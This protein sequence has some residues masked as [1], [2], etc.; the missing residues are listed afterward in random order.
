MKKLALFVAVAN[1]CILSSNA[2]AGYGHAGKAYTKLDLGWGVQQ[3]KQTLSGTLATSGEDL[4]D[5]IAIGAGLGYY[6][7]DS[8]RFDGMLYYDRGMKSKV[9]AV[10][11]ATNVTIRGKEQSLGFFVN[12]TYDFLN[13]S[14]ITPY[15]TGGAGFLRNEF[16]TE[17]VTSTLNKAGKS[18]FN[19]AY[20][21][22]VGISYHISS[23]LDI[24][25]GYRYIKKGSDKYNLTLSA[26]STTVKAETEPEH[27][28]IIGFRS[29]F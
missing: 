14:N 11:G 26:I 8:L 23:A 22:G 1:I 12:A 9:N 19:M 2:N 13:S 7:F 10:S 15:V 6:F 5:G 24:D 28:G 25:L 27:V 18:S 21:G 29:T 3:N 16:K 4:G 20:Q 17:I